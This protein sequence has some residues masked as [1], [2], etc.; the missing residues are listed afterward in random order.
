MI[1]V[2]KITINGMN[3]EQKE[4]NIYIDGRHIDTKKYKGMLLTTMF[5]LGAFVG[6]STLTILLIAGEYLIK[7]SK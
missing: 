2:S 4:D 7:L 3:I 1:E 6:V 5:F